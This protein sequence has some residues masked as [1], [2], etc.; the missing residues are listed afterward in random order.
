MKTEEKM[1]QCLFW[2]RD[3]SCKRKNLLDTNVNPIKILLSCLSNISYFI[4]KADQL[5]QITKSI[6]QQPMA[7]FIFQGNAAPTLMVM[8]SPQL[9]NR[10]SILSG[11]R[12]GKIMSQDQ[13]NCQG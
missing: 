12:L 4:W 2:L 1:K 9:I 10:V 6:L 11:L 5:K 8:G 13:E 3:R 7:H